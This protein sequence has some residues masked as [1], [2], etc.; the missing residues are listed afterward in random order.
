MAFD[1]LSGAFR[2]TNR[3]LGVNYFAAARK[4]P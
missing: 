3:D 1:P 2:L 4:L